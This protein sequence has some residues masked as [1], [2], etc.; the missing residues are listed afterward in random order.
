MEVHSVI[1]SRAG[2][3]DDIMPAGRPSKFKRSNFGVRLLNARQQAG[4]SQR[5]VAERL[6]VTQQTY[7]GWERKITALKPEYITQLA[8]VLKVSSD[9][10]LGRASSAHRGSG[11]VGKALKIFEEVSQLPRSRQ[12]RIIMVVEDMLAAKRYARTS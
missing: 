10:L 3:T 9:Y 4:L 11:P 7:A 8:D 5:Q 1:I 2:Y 12:Q 6:K